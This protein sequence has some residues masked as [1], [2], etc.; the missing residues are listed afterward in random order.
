MFQDTE[1]RVRFV[2][3]NPLLTD[4]SVSNL[5]L[6]CR[7]LKDDKSQG[8]EDQSTEDSEESKGDDLR[9]DSVEM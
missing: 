9:A 7:Y 3:R 2:I 1:L 6:K 4:I 5:R 8:G